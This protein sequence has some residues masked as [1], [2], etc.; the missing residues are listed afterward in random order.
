[1]L[2]NLIPK[3]SRK[4]SKNLKFSSIKFFQNF[5]RN[6]KKIGEN[7]DFTDFYDSVLG[8]FSSERA[9]KMLKNDPLDVK[10]LDDTAENEPLQISKI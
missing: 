9:L 2:Q 8:M 3:T 10:K 4:S 5:A 1:M 7:L 6:F